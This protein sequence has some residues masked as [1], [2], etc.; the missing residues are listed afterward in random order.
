VVDHWLQIQVPTP[1]SSKLLEMHPLELG[2]PFQF[3][4]YKR[5]GAQTDGCEEPNEI[6]RKVDGKNL[7]RLL[8]KMQISFL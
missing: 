2:L 5:N 7:Q 6:L 3:Q 1:T 4:P 8:S